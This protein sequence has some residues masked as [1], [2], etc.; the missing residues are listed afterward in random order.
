[1]AEVRLS[2][3]QVLCAVNNLFLGPRTHSS[4]LYEIELGERRESQSSSG[5]IVSTGLGSSAW[6]KSVVTG[7][8]G[9]AHAMK[10]WD[11]D[12][13]YTPQPWDSPELTFAVREPFPSRVSKAELVFGHFSAKQP[14]RLRSRMPENGVIFSD[15]MEA[16]YLRFTA[17]MEATVSVAARKG[18]LVV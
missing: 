17:G 7:S 6:I 10:G 2:D 13:Q 5:I 1:M 4:A 8:L 11:G 14:L 18:C 3:G 9:V 16:D 12:F 15:G